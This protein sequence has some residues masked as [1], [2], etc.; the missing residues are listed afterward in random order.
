VS[1]ASMQK[2][3]TTTRRGRQLPVAGGAP[4]WMVTYGDMVTLLLTIFVLMLA[5]SQVK[6]DQHMV[7]FM[8]AVKEAF[9]Y[10]GG[11]RYLPTEE[12]EVPKN[13]DE[14]TTLVMSIFPEDA[15]YTSDEGP[16]GKRH[17]VETIRPGNHYQPGGQFHFAPLS[18]EL[19]QAEIAAVAEYARQLRGHATLIKVRGHCSKLP[20]NGTPFR[21]HMDLSIQRAWTVARILVENGVDPQRIHI[22]GAGTTQPITRSAYDVAEQQ[23]NDVAELLQADQTM[24]DF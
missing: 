19:S 18:A 5:M 13:V 16:R 22:T 12:V 6:E 14:M 8:Q 9:G 3:A 23:R 2:G 17:T 11:A 4:A 20:V 1:A 15:G 7:E 24:D 10:T 21:D